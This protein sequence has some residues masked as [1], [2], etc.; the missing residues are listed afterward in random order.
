M[1]FIRKRLHDPLATKDSTMSRGRQQAARVKKA[2][3]HHAGGQRHTGGL[4]QQL[5]CCVQKEEIYSHAVHLGQSRL[6]VFSS[7]QIYLRMQQ[8]E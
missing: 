6:F 2:F 3:Q 5:H 8:Q 4:F 1:P 7:S